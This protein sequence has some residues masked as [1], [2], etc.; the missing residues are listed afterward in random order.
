MAVRMRVG[1][2]VNRGLRVG[3]ASDRAVG[4]GQQ[5]LRSVAKQRPCRYKMAEYRLFLEI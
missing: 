4:S 5:D 3:C 1:L 2:R